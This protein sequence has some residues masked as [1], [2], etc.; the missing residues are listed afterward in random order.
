M[1]RI[2]HLL[3]I[4]SI[5]LLSNIAKAG[6]FNTKTYDDCVLENK[7]PQTFDFLQI[8]KK[9]GVKSWEDVSKDE[10]YIN[11]SDSDKKEVRTKY[12]DAV[13]LPNI[14]QDFKE[15][16]LYQFKKYTREIKKSLN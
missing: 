12:F 13:I 7:H 9:A 8:S 2:L 11:L 1:I 3:I 14:H 15:E 4:I 10:N 5:M 6:W 16:A